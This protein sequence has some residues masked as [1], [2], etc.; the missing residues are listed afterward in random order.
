MKENSN[1]SPPSSGWATFLNILGTMSLVIGAIS[2][3]S[4]DSGMV[5]NVS[6][7]FVAVGVGLQLLMLAHLIKLFTNMHFYLKGI[8]EQ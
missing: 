8:Y 4:E 1:I 6:V 7:G 5:G 2:V 3:V